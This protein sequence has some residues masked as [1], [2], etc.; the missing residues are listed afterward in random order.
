MAKKVN[1]NE[2]DDSALLEMMGVP[3][4]SS[5]APTPVQNAAQNIV[6]AAAPVPVALTEKHE[7]TA[8]EV[9]QTPKH[10][11]SVAEAAEDVS[12][13]AAPAPTTENK[14]PAPARRKTQGTYEETFLCV[15]NIGCLRKPIP[16]SPELHKKLDF[17]VRV[18]LDGSISLS[19]LVENILSHH[20]E[21]YGDELRSMLNNRKWSF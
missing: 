15:R 19:N 2:F 5:G 11:G 4:G 7:R 6:P 18:A 10:A 9:E 21:V 3:G 16:V 13:L 14:K 8:A 1:L 17:L 12:T 20:I